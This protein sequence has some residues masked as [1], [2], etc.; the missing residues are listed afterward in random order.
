M[1]LQYIIGTTIYPWKYKIFLEILNIIGATKYRWNPTIRH[2]FLN[3]FILFQIQSRQVTPRLNLTR[4]NPPY[5]NPTE[6]P[7]LEKEK[8]KSAKFEKVLSGSPV[9]IAELEKL[10]WSGVPQPYRTRVWKMLCGYLPAG[11]SDQVLQ[12]KREEYIG[13]VN[14]YFNN[15]E[16][17][18]HKDTFRFKSKTLVLSDHEKLSSFANS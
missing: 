16:E 2:Y 12:R 15:K 6:S 11:K 4:R 9:S 18:I 3:L 7:D 5:P 14:Q 17:D 13:Y 8:T 1:E 10:S